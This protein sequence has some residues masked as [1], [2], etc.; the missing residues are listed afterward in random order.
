MSLIFIF[1]DQAQNV[2][3]QVRQEFEGLHQLLR[4][5]E[6]ARITALREEEEEKY[7]KMKRR[8]E[9]L[10]REISTL[11]ETIDVIKQEMEEEDI[12]FLKVWVNSRLIK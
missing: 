2:E 7:E 4:E 6:A 12:V 3:Q 8:M 1:Q 11:S 9:K 5:E 10:I